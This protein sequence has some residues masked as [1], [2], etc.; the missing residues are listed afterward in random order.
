MTNE[1]TSPVL[2]VY[3]ALFAFGS[4]GLLPIYWKAIQMV[5]PLSILCHRMIWACLFTGVI[6]A[7]QKRWP[8]IRQ[9][10]FHLRTL[11]VLLLTS[12]LI[13]IN[14][15]TYILGV[16]TDRV[17]ETA[18]GYYINPL[19]NVLL[20]YLVFRD[21]LRPAQVVSILC[22]AIGVGYMV[23]DYGHLPWISLC[24]AVTFSLYGLVHKMIR[25]LPLPG[26]F[27]ETV[28]LSVPASV[29]L[30]CFSPDFS[31]WPEQMH[32]RIMLPLAGVVTTL[33]LWTFTIAAKNLRLVTLGLLQF[34][35]PTL[36][37]L[38]GVFVYHEPFTRTH[39]V[40]FAFI[41]TGLLIYS[42]ESWRFH[43]SKQNAGR[44]E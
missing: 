9:S 27:V 10:V 40:T 17:V 14:W 18:L 21:N 36:A 1:K 37:F 25:V 38:L 5:P 26:L 11:G 23:F 41:W 35:S 7:I 4:W 30:F 24:L 29:Y 32:V 20:G 12:M 31:M 6:L 22:A 42:I 44:K 13:G 3:A 43:S 16:N 39:L 34:L 19:C 33:P 28:I 15:G 2:G 8:E